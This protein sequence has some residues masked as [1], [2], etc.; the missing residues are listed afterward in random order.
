M[1]YRLLVVTLSI[2]SVFLCA[3][4]SANSDT[5]DKNQMER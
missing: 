4:R 3:E 5:Y 2:V 1:A